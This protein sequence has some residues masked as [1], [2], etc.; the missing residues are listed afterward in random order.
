MAFAL[1]LPNLG[2]MPPHFLLAKQKIG[3]VWIRA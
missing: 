3:R 1:M 2:D